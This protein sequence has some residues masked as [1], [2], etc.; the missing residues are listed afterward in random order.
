[1]STS[2]LTQSVL[3][4]ITR[5]LERLRAEVEQY[6]DEASLWRDLPGIANPGG[7]LAAH[8]T[9][10]LR[11]YVGGLLGGSGYVRDRPAEFGRRDRSRAELI[12]GLVAA[13]REVGVALSRLPD[14]AL[15]GEFPEKV[16]GVARSTG[17]Q[18]VLLAAHLAYHLGQVNY[19]RR[20]VS[21]SRE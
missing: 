2:P 9:G 18:L 12:E 16:G 20:I 5:D 19:H 10:N 14:E 15:A 21:G 1:M 13:E 17:D 4:V 6:P 8:C 11:H 7:V 3:Q